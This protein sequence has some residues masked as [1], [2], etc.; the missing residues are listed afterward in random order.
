M[1]TRTMTQMLSSAVLRSAFTITSRIDIRTVLI[2]Y[3]SYLIP[4][5][6]IRTYSV[7]NPFTISQFRSRN[8]SQFARS[9]AHF[10]ARCGPMARSRLRSVC[11]RSVVVF[12]H[13]D[14]GRGHIAAIARSCTTDVTRVM[15]TPEPFWDQ[16]RP[17]FFCGRRATY[18]A[19]SLCDSW[20][21]EHWMRAWRARFTALSC[22]FGRLHI[23]KVVLICQTRV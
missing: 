21:H 22:H 17:Q 4:T 16:G 8:D 2:G 20:C 1:H 3:G 6:S 18:I 10:Q 5:L 15:T 13:S 7:L 11:C 9:K 19:S 23:N 14:C 12:T